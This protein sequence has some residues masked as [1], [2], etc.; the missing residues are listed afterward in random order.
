[1]FGSFF[2]RGFQT[3]G[4][5]SFKNFTK[6]QSKSFSTNNTFKNFENM[7]KN[8]ARQ[9]LN[10]N[11][12]AIVTLS[13]KLSLVNAFDSSMLDELFDDQDEDG[14]RRKKRR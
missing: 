14:Q 13:N 8:A 4:K 10:A 9:Q 2:K 6:S 1:M 5:Q 11:I 7:T 3:F 12:A